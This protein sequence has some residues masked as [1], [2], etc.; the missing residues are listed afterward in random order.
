MIYNKAQGLSD[1]ISIGGIVQVNG[2]Q[3]VLM[4]RT[5]PNEAPLAK[6]ILYKLFLVDQTGWDL[7]IRDQT[8][9]FWSAKH[10]SF[11]YRMKL[12]ECGKG[13]VNVTKR[14]KGLIERIEAGHYAN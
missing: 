5:P 10:K 3:T 13:L 8:V 6:A 1:Q 11:A 12:H 9:T 2:K 4:A 14:A 7:E